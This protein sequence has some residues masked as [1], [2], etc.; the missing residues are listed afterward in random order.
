MKQKG[1]EPAQPLPQRKLYYPFAKTAA[2]AGLSM[3]R[4]STG[5]ALCVLGPQHAAAAARR[6]AARH[7]AARHA[8]APIIGRGVGGGLLGVP[9]SLQR[10]EQAAARTVQEALEVGGRLEPR[11]GA[12][13]PAE[14]LQVRDRV[15]TQVRGHPRAPRRGV[16]AA[17]AH[18]R[19]RG[20]QQRQARLEPRGGGRRAAG[21]ARERHGEVGGVEGLLGLSRW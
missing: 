18:A 6:A 16:E 3:R 13:Q 12:T 7:A 21:G 15:R 10:R 4:L 5:A 9:L 19:S 20:A 1:E 2:T 8:A 14:H 11:R 17:A